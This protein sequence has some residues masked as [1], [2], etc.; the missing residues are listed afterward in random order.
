MLLPKKTLQNEL[1]VN[2]F[3][4]K[5]NSRRADYASTESL[6]MAQQQQQQQH[7][8]TLDENSEVRLP[9]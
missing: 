8:P 9:D 5:I 6:H 1:N 4:I 2:Y 3:Y 7:Q